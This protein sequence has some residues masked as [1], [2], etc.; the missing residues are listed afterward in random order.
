M[1]MNRL[2]ETAR[3]YLRVGLCV[4]PAV[5]TERRP[6][7]R[8]WK[9]WQEWIITPEELEDAFST[10]DIADAVAIVTGAVSGGV[11]MIDFDGMGELFA[12]WKSRVPMELLGRM[13]TE[14]SQ[15]GGFHVI[16]R[17]ETVGGN[18][19]LAQRYYDC[20]GDSI[21]IYGK[22]YR[23]QNGRVRVTLIETRGEGGLFLCAP[24]PGYSL[25]QG[26]F[27]SIATISAS[28]RDQLITAAIE[29][30]EV[31][32]AAPVRTF[33]RPSGGAGMPPG[34]D[35]NARGD[36]SG[37]LLRHGW[38]RVSFGENQH[39]RRPGKTDGMSATLKN[40]VF[41]VFSSNAPPFEPNHGY[42]F[43][44]VYGLLAHDGDFAAAARQLRLNGYG[45]IV[46]RP[47]PLSPE[48]MA[49]ALARNLPGPATTEHTTPPNVAVPVVAD[50]G[51]GYA[52]T[53]G[54]HYKPD[55]EVL[56]VG[57]DEFARS[58]WDLMPDG[59]LYRFAGQVVEIIDGAPV[60]CT[61]VHMCQ[62]LDALVPIREC[63]RYKPDRGG[64][65][66]YSLDEKN[67]TIPLAMHV[68]DYARFHAPRIDV[69]AAFPIFNRDWELVPVGYKDG[70]YCTEAIGYQYEPVSVILDLLVD[71]PFRTTCDRDN[72]IGLMLLPMVRYA[73]DGNCPMH[74]IKSTLPRTGKTKLAEAVLGLTYGRPTP[75]M[76]LGGSDE[77]SDKRV[78][79]SLMRGHNIMHLD[80]TS[81]YIDSP[82]LASLLTCR[83]Y[84]GRTLGRSEMVEI[85]NNCTLVATGN[86]PK[87]SREIARRTCPIE[88]SPTTSQP[89]F[90]TGFVH[91]NIED[92]ALE[93]R[94]HVIGA[95]ATMVHTWV[96]AGKP[97]CG[98]TLGGFERWTEVIGG[99]MHNSGLTDWMGNINEWVGAVDPETDDMAA[100][101]ALWS[102]LAAI[103]VGLGKTGQTASE[104]LQVALDNGLFLQAIR[105]SSQRAM[106]QSFARRI[107]DRYE[108]APLGGGHMF[109]RLSSR[110][111]K[112]W[113]LEKCT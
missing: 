81:G 60:V 75:A 55:G 8:E 88:L 87:M 39:W 105:G 4:L 109:S 85:P 107:L 15:S 24:S 44:S 63:K 72:F 70:I 103:D 49:G 36:I 12:D 7:V 30:N 31:E 84:M 50:Q 99:I 14:R 37:L 2:L 52:L 43:F 101:L 69:F 47:A 38:T 22:T 42:S 59:T 76:Q 48:V 90:R 94:G 33:T 1:D 78:V 9:R 77:E 20:P 92:Y 67:S 45:G 19:K 108:G 10:T 11:E 82:V 102:G 80:N 83:T 79:A 61:P 51:Q 57:Q 41:Y 73:I 71:F 110:T 32:Q 34:D 96:L 27:Q 106:V 17:C 97:R 62:L 91:A 54:R 6:A 93:R 53:P 35:F 86:N 95:L 46:D 25:I 26:T 111:G 29:L 23:P 74:M 40:N 65:Y 64:D 58:A 56:W 13:V 89:E 3:D 18:Q 66:A 28:E 98:V 100:F 113:K 104:L 21:V 112:I 16:Y 5:S 68:L